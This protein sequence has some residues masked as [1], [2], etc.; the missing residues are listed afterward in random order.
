MTKEDDRT[1]EATFDLVGQQH[2]E[3]EFRSILRQS[4]DLRKEDFNLKESFAECIEKGKISQK[5]DA[6]SDRARLER[7]AL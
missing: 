3:P 4:A 6:K 2:S 1:A 5:S 7:F